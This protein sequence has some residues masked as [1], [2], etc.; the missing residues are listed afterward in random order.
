MDLLRGK[1]VVISGGATLIG[2]AV[3]QAFKAAGAT[4]VIADINPAETAERI[5]F[6][7]TD[8]TR[9][10][11]LDRCLATTEERHGGID[12]L[13]NVA[14]SYVDNAMRSTR[15]EWLS[16]LN[17]NVVS[18]AM[19]AA[20]ARPYL[21]RRDRAAIVNFSS[22]SA[23]SAQAGRMVYSTSKAAIMGLTRAQALALAPDGIRVN[24][25]AP[26]WTWSNVIRDL[27]GDDR[28][29]ADKV[30]APFHLN[31]RLVDAEEVAAA[32]LFL[33]SPAASGINGTELSV[34]GGY[35]AIGPEQQVGQIATLV[36]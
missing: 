27:S 20:K 25:V 17:V 29:K 24:A 11:A 21:I 15:D 32:V 35:R 1:V 28:V 16:A 2:L 4:A 22:V 8:I 6:I 34:D 13:V 5:D 18:A 31:G 19:F 3:A 26:G 30:A 7:H 14:C 36:G 9:D 33:C 12:F 23:H 10:D